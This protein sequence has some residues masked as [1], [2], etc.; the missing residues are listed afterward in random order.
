MHLLDGSVDPL[1]RCGSG[2]LGGD[3]GLRMA[4]LHGQTAGGHGCANSGTSGGA[5][6]EGEAGGLGGVGAAVASIAV[7]GGSPECTRGLV[8]RTRAIF[9][10]HSLST[11]GRCDGCASRWPF[12]GSRCVSVLLMLGGGSGQC[13]CG[14]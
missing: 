10:L 8:L 14:M 1:G 5:V 2:S 4:F 11:R 7:S 6:L 3:C 9:N 12:W 13:A